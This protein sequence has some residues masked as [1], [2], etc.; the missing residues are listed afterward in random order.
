[1]AKMLR[2]VRTLVVAGLLGL[3]GGWAMPAALQAEGGEPG[4]CEED[5]RCNSTGAECVFGPDKGCEWNL[6]GDCHTL[7]L[8]C[9]PD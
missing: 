9:P 2:S 6:I 3:V 5:K 8:G 4:S 1:M 7:A